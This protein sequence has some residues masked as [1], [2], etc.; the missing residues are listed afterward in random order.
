MRYRIFDENSKIYIFPIANNT[1]SINKAPVNGM[2]C[3][4]ICFAP[5]TRGNLFYAIYG[6]RDGDI[7]F[8]GASHKTIILILVK[9]TISKLQKFFIF[10]T[11]NNGL[12]TKTA[13]HLLCNAVHCIF[14]SVFSLP[15]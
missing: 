8:P 7:L 14:I 15:A 12:H 13:L 3:E 5:L 6:L 4:T 1:Y 9:R 2:D 11:E 10:E